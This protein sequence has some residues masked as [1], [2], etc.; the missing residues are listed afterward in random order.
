MEVFHEF[1][2]GNCSKIVQQLVTG[3]L[4]FEDHST[5]RN[6]R[7]ELE[8]LKITSPGRSMDLKAICEAKNGIGG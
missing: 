6:L 3:W 7:L 1:F 2:L 5:E 8:H 4:N